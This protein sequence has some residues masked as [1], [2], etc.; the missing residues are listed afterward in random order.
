MRI[1]LTAD[2]VGGVWQYAT[3]LASGLA[4]LG[5]ET[6]LAVMGPPPSSQQRD[7]ARSIA[8]LRLLETD[9]P[10]DWLADDP[11][12][13]AAAGREIAR[14]ADGH[15]IDVVQLHAGALA[16][17]AQFGRPVLAVAHSC[18][19]TW[20][21]ATNGGEPEEPFRWRSHL[22]GQGLARVD[23]VVAPTAAFAGATRAVHKL[24][25]LPTT[26]HNGRSSSPA[27]A[28]AARGFAFTAGR[29]WDEGKNL[30]TLDRAASGLP[31]PFRAA[32]PLNGPG[33][34]RVELAHIQ[35]L[36][37]LSDEEVASWLA[38]RPV[39]ASAALYEPFGL[40][41]LEAAAAGCPL[42]LSNI[43]TFRELWQGVAV[44]VDPMDEIG[45]AEAI[46]LV[47]HDDFAS[48]E[49]SRRA[50]LR[51]AEFSVE[52]M[53]AKMADIYRSL[54]ADPLAATGQ[55]QVAAA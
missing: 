52:A 35:A 45:F 46:R 37:T 20:W 11:A 54:L 30:A 42:V 16:A 21:R 15:D 19:G 39:F 1:L 14:L 7:K 51:A 40:A 8:G 36:G 33:G 6:V 26:V 22:T 43:P 48:A 2:A 50:R 9:L 29:L 28:V 34:D 53:A 12:E 32:G 5:V 17:E 27:V 23:R 55:V 10:L 31:V 18:L 44:F 24:G 49:M 41:V 47:V 38:A 3:D 13:V 4:D 25:E